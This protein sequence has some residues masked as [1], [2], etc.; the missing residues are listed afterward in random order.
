MFEKGRAELLAATPAE[1]AQDMKAR[2]PD[3]DLAF[4][5]DEAVCM[6]QAYASGIDGC[7][8]D[9][10]AQV[11]PRGFDLA[12][13][14]VPPGSKPLYLANLFEFLYSQVCERTSMMTF[15]VACAARQEYYSEYVDDNSSG[16]GRADGSFTGPRTR[17][18]GR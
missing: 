8:D 17:R 10:W 6:Q 14:S 9:C 7:W 12:Q 5:T 15:T 18:R 11:T 13:I 3:A 1:L 2:S 4:L 16:D